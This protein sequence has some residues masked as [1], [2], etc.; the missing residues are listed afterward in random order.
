MP[1]LSPFGWPLGITVVLL[2]GAYTG[3]SRSIQAAQEGNYKAAFALVGVAAI[4]T[5]LGWL[6][7]FELTGEISR[8]VKANRAIKKT[9]KR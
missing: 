5:A 7:L 3:F 6:Q 2:A 4:A 8:I 9:R 1:R